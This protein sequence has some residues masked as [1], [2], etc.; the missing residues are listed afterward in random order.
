M[1]VKLDNFLTAHLTVPHSTLVSRWLINTDS[2][3]PQK[4]VCLQNGY[5]KKISFTLALLNYRR[6]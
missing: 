5:L 4:L 3:K 1:K 2:H 6:K